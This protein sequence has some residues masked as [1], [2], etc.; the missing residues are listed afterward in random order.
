MDYTTIL[1]EARRF[2]KT[3]TTS[4]QTAD[5]TESVNR[6]YDRVV[7]LI[8]Q[9]SGRWQWDDT[10]QTDLPVATTALVS[11][12]Q[13]Y[14]LDTN[15]YMVERVE[16]K[17]EVG[18]WTRLAPF[19]KADIFDQSITDFLS[20]AGMPQYYDIV[21]NSVLLYPKPSYAQNAS[22]KVFCQRGPSYFTVSDSTKT[23]GFAPLFHRLLPLWAAYDYCA[24]N[25]VATADRFK[26]DIQE[27]EAALTEH[28]AR[29][30]KDEHTTLKARVLN[31][32]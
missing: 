29:R 1:S 14:Q 23:P 8:N 30:N 6:A 7:S 16:V 27:L 4:Y 22:L 12:Q 5:I 2:T 26:A 20:G 21:G 3:N 18:N 13:D 32:R 9:A 19:D 25:L 15:F 11:S 28:Y 17:D 10:N 31:Y 24:I